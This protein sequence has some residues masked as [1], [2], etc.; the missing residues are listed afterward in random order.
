MRFHIPIITAMVTKLRN[1]IIV[2]VLRKH[3]VAGEEL[4][5]RKNCLELETN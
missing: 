5:G 1:S 4:I 3:L 2:F